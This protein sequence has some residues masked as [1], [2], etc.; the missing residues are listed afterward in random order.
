MSA[1]PASRA[2]TDDP[3]RSAPA[4]E[5]GRRI[6]VLLAEGALAF[7]VFTALAL[8]VTWPLVESL[9]TGIL[10][11]VPRDG[12]GGVAWL[13]QLES[14]G[15]F[16]VLGTT[17]HTLTGAPL[18][19]EGG[20][21]LNLQWLLPY[22]PAHL[23]V[24]AVGE[25]AAFNLVVLSGLV[26]SALAMY[27]LAR[28]LGCVP[29]VA[30]WA[31]LVYMLFPWHLERAYAGHGSLVHIE[32]FPLLV[33]VLLHWYRRPTP[34]RAAL[35]GA[36]TLAAWLTSA[37]WGVMAAIGAVAFAAVATAVRAR[38]SGLRSPAT[39]LVVVTALVA[40]VPVGLGAVSLL[41]TS[42][43]ASPRIE[44]DVADLS[45]YGARPAELVVPAFRNP[46]LGL[47]FEDYYVPR[48][49]GSNISETTLYLGW[50]TLALGAVGAAV[51]LRRRRSPRG[52]LGRRETLALLGVG[53]AGLAFA[54]PSPLDLRGLTITATPSW[55][56]WNLVGEVRVPSRF[57]LLTMTAL[58]PLAALG[59]QHVWSAAARRWPGPAGRRLALLAG[60]AALTISLLELFP[61]IGLVS[62]TDRP[63]DVYAALAGTPEGVLAEYPLV[64]PG[65]FETSGYLLWQRFHER[66]LLNGA[67]QGSRADDVRRAAIDPNAAGTPSLLALLGVTAVVTHPPLDPTVS[68]AGAPDIAPLSLGSGYE[69]VRRAS[70]GSAVWRVT[71][72]PAP[73][74]ATLPAESFEVPR[75]GADGLVESPLREQAGVIELAS[76]SA[77]DVRLIFSVRSP[78]DTRLEIAGASGRVTV[79]VGPSPTRVTVGVALPRGTSELRVA[80]AD[81]GGG[82]TTVSVSELETERA[83]RATA[84]LS[85]T[86]R[87]PDP[88]F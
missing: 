21:A 2:G 43:D 68:G 83:E 40:A 50:L 73:A 75:R 61:P 46:F 48:L 32:A 30:G 58:V 15:G 65:R 45:R 52:G 39:S 34:R 19:W 59:L 23:L 10:G 28:Y 53:I 56:L 87:A 18:G 71:A 74:L 79:D 41:G 7:G 86:P 66:P 55:L 49:H 1:H 72:P 14:E 64:E 81:P 29:V 12:A 31:G 51:G 84:A 37:Y 35:V 16:H 6:H 44:R 63:P 42:D 26:L 80:V 8:L 33:L 38:A 67:G 17:A 60:A 5:T 88:G 47:S 54:A 82:T 69:L 27:A 3:D 62:R 11:V 22:Y 4:V 36:V 13:W 20:N 85:A 77:Q 24:A 70:D 25:T 9:G 78:K 57:V 76:R